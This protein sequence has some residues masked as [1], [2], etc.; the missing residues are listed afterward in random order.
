MNVLLVYPR[1]PETFWSFSNVLS[2][3]SKKA[4]FPPLG[5][6]TIAAMLPEAWNRRLV[7]ANVAPLRDEDLAWADLVMISA[8]LIQVEPAREI[9]AR[10]KALGQDRGRRRAGLQRPARAFSRGGPPGPERGRGHPAA[11]PGRVRAGRGRAYLR[12][13]GRAPTLALTPVPDWSLIDMK[14]YATMSV[15]YSR[16]CP[17]NC[18]FCDIVIMNGRTPR[19][20][21]PEQ[22]LTE[23]QALYDAGWRSTVFVVDDNFIGNTVRVKG[24]LRALVDWQKARGYPFTFLTEAST[25]LADDQELMG[26]MSAANFSKVFLGIETPSVE[27]L[28]EC[29][30]HQNAT[31]NLAEAVRTIQ[32]QGLQVMGGFIVGFDHDTERIFESQIGFIQKVGVVTAMVGLLNAIPGTRLWHRLKAE[33]R[34]LGEATGENTDGT[35]NF[36]PRMDRET[37]LA[38]YRKILATI[39]SPKHYYRRVSTFIA[40]YNPTVRRRLTFEELRAFAKSTVRIGL[41]SRASL[42]YWKLLIKTALTKRQALPTAVELAIYWLHFNKVAR[43][44]MQRG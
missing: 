2:F 25:N 6:L 27:S 17:F 26:L 19:T 37:L 1:Y 32:S 4:A 20:K 28:K 42:Q 44:V 15:Q 10:A 29:G 24:M 39:Y 41:V 38:G 36:V 34:L 12:L 11:L 33:G 16:G 18:E 3:I 5:L 8:M 35:I 14:Q 22:M 43:R 9:V 21:S 31:R 40:N 7:D 30:K 23:L 13:Q